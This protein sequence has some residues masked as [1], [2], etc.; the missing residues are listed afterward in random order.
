MAVL[1]A[2]DPKREG[3]GPVAFVV[4]GAV[5]TTA[6]VWLAAIVG[7]VTAATRSF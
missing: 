6:V 7:L 5:G 2:W 4:L 1:L 3:R